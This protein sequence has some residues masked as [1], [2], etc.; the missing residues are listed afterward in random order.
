MYV[1]SVRYVQLVSVLV[2]SAVGV[3]LSAWM[4]V[5]ECFGEDTNRGTAAR[6]TCFATF[7]GLC[8]GT[9]LWALDLGWERGPYDDADSDLTM[10]MYVMCGLYIAGAVLYAVRVPEVRRLLAF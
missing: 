6:L 8:M 4:V 1:H 7:L 3:S 9:G 10:R 2:V 5:A